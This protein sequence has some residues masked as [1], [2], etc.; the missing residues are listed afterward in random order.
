MLKKKMPKWTSVILT[1]KA[2]DDR[3][4]VVDRARKIVSVL[5]YNFMTYVDQETPTG[6]G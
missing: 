4:Q 1:R 6:L 5:K 2:I 3:P